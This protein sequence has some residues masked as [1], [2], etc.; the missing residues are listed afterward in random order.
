MELLFDELLLA[1]QTGSFHPGENLRQK[2][3]LDLLL[4]YYE[5]PLWR[6]DY[7]ADER[8]ELPQALKR[9]ILSEDGFYHFISDIKP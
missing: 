4:A 9:G 3:S 5:S 8:G 7:E 2:E 6:S 1:V